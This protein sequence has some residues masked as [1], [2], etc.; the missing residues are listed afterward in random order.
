MQ[1]TNKAD[2][3]SKGK[4]NRNR[5]IGENWKLYE[6]P[7]ETASNFAPNIFGYVL[8]IQYSFLHIFWRK[9]WKINA[10]L[11]FQGTRVYYP[12]YRLII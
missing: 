8:S 10:F 4:Q 12:A 5:I 11:P 7:N 3:Q 1:M 9:L 6:T 2:P